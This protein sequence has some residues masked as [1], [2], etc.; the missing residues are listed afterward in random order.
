PS[1][2][3]TVTGIAQNTNITSWQYSVNGGSFSTTV[4]TG[5][6]RSGE[7]VTI[8][9]N[10]VT[11]KTLSIRASDGTNSDTYTIA[12]VSD[13]QAPYLECWGTSAL[14]S[15]LKGGVWKNGEVI[16]TAGSRGH[17]VVVL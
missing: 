4:P 7:T 14:A 3:F 12:V 16:T 15:P 2:S 1:T 9:P 11:F 5:V 6:S 17:R 10:T 8:D 13:G